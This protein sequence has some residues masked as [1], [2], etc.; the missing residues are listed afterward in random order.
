MSSKVIEICNLTCKN[1]ET[2]IDGFSVSYLSALLQAYFPS[3]IPILDRRVLINLHLVSESD[4]DKQ[5]QIKNIQQFYKP[6]IE[7]IAFISKEK[8]QTL[9]AIDKDLFVISIEKKL[10]DN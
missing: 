10:V 4:R 6:L 9:R 2:R 1:S 5:D 3:L 7:K 8:K